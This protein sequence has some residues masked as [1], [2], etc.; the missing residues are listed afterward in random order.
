MP[1]ILNIDLLRK[2]CILFL[3]I[4]CS[5]FLNKLKQIKRTDP[6]PGFETDTDRRKKFGSLRIRNTTCPTNKSLPTLRED[7]IKATFIK[8]RLLIL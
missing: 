7:G 5:H 4:V 2:L 8:K 1:K 3:K 6:D